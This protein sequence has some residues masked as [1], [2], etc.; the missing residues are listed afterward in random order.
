M[1]R[2]T[3]TTNVEQLQPG[4]YIDSH[5][6]HYQSVRALEI[7]LDLGWVP[8]GYTKEEVYARIEAYDKNEI[9]TLM[10]GKPLEENEADASEHIYWLFEEA[11]EWINDNAVPDNHWFGHHP[12]LGD[13]GVW[14][15][16]EDE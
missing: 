4:T 13:I 12:D 8:N 7:A 9:P 5:W 16:D 2:D 3:N 15:V 11:E 6:G 10:N 1:T 14:E